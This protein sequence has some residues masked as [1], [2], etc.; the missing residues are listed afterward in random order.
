MVFRKIPKKPVDIR[1]SLWYK[2]EALWVIV[3]QVPQNVKIFYP[4]WRNPYVHYSSEEGDPG[5]QVV[6]H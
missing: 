5:A 1:F 6:R 4:N 2:E 3:T